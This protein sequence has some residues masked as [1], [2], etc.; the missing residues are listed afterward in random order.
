MGC[1]RACST[2]PI[3]GLASRRRPCLHANFL[4]PKPICHSMGWPPFPTL[5]A[6]R[7][8]HR[9]VYRATIDFQSL[10]P[11]CV[12]LQQKATVSLFAVRGRVNETVRVVAATPP[13]STMDKAP[14]S[15]AAP[16]TFQILVQKSSVP[17]A[18]SF[19][20]VGAAHGAR[21]HDQLFA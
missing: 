5:P 20:V 16:E 14:A 17:L 1:I 21:V 8:N 18:N 2:E 11:V 4:P 6:C 7:A 3:P 9:L 15:A 12:G 10:M 19:T 13:C